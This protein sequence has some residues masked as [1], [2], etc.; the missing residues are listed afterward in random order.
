MI[1]VQINEK[2]KSYPIIFGG[3]SAEKILSFADGYKSLAVISEKVYKLYK[4]KLS[5]L[6]NACRIF[7]LKDGEKEKN[8]KNYKKILDAAMKTGLSRKD[9][10][11][12]IGG[13]AAGDLA[14]FAAAVYMRGIDLIQVPTTLLACV[15]SSV[16]GKTAVN[17][18]YGKNLIG[19]FHQPKAVLIDVDFL[20]TL[21]DKQFKTGLG[22]VVKYAFIE[23]SCGG[24]YHL[25]NFLNENSEKILRRDPK[26]LT[27]LIEICIKLKAAV[28]QRDEKESGLRRIL[29]LGHTYGHA[30]EKETRYKKYTHGE[31]VAAGIKYAFKLALQKGLID[32]DYAFFADD[33]MNKFGFCEI[34][35]F[36]AKRMIAHMKGDKKSSGGKITFILPVGC[37]EVE[38]FEI[39]DV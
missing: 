14:G 15:D 3:V 10:I 27:Q 26:I 28:V 20:T 25:I 9:A 12:A 36:P 5:P 11:I 13:G 23:K 1:N 22:E 21:D 17:T 38:A 39:D 16:G 7:I 4:Q 35:E 8:F 19:A 24:E 32:K 33:L 34:P 18:D 6:E 2:P 37:A 30:I 29:N 31:A